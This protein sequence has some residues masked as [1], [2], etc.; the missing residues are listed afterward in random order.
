MAAFGL[1]FGRADPSAPGPAAEVLLGVL[2]QGWRQGGLAL[3]PVGPPPPPLPDAPWARALGLPPAALVLALQSWA[4][5]QGQ[6]TLEVFGHLRFAAPDA[7]P[8]FDAV[9]EDLVQ[10]L[11]RSARP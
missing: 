3:P 4:R 10:G 5:V 7:G 6:V 2:A 9:V 11:S 1:L 8:L